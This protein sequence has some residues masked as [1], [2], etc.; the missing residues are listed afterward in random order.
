MADAPAAARRGGTAT[1]GMWSAG[2]GPGRLVLAHSPLTANAQAGYCRASPGS[3]EPTPTPIG[4][5]H[6]VSTPVFN[7]GLSVE[8]IIREAPECTLPA[9]STGILCWVHVIPQAHRAASGLPCLHS[10]PPKLIRAVHLSASS[11]AGSG[12]A[13]TQMTP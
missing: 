2:C 13:G 5:A 11:S 12:A 10:L 9:A 7:H 6:C 1:G 3:Q 8:T 4:K